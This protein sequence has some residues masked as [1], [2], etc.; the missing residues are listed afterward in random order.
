MLLYLIFL[1]SPGVTAHQFLEL[2]FGARAV[3]MA[4]TYTGVSDDVY[5]I[6]YNP[7][8]LR[9]EKGCNMALIFSTLPLDVSLASGA[10]KYHFEGIGTV[11]GGFAF[12]S[13][14]DIVWDEYGT[15]VDEFGINDLAI[16][17][18]YAFKAKKVFMMGVTGKGIYS[19]L[20][21]YKSFSFGFDAGILYSLFDI[22]YLG[23]SL[24]DVGIGSKFHKERDL[25]PTSISCGTSIR[26]SVKDIA[27]FVL[28]FDTKAGLGYS[29]SYTLGGEIRIHLPGENNSKQHISGLALRAGY[30]PMHYFRGES[31][32]GSGG[33]TTGLGIECTLPKMG[34]LLLFDIVYRDYGY[35]GQAEH[36]SISFV[37]K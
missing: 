25:A 26:L 16:F 24:K 36:L 6:F 4:G 30:D 22:I 12:F 37:G 5:A 1:F 13:T 15:K 35:F 29:P 21:D 34:F 8:G 17:L 11:A 7:A 31:E 27:R 18:S 33:L 32:P 19:R 14:S 2:G 20:S 9:S 28:A 3:A 10:I 23:A